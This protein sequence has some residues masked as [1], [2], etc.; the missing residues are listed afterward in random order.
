M[1]RE[2]VQAVDGATSFDDVVTSHPNYEINGISIH[3]GAVHGYLISTIRNFDIVREAL[4]DRLSELPIVYWTDE[5]HCDDLAALSHASG[6]ICSNSSPNSWCAVQSKSESLP[7]VIGLPEQIGGHGRPVGMRKVELRLRDGDARE[8][9]LEVHR[10]TFPTADG[11]EVDLHEGDLVT[12]D[13]GAGRLLVGAADVVSS[14]PRRFYR[15]LAEAVTGSIRQLGPVDG[16]TRLR[17]SEAYAHRRGELVEL[18]RDDDVRAFVS[19]MAGVRNHAFP[20]PLGTVHTVD[21]VVETR[22]FYSDIAL[23]DADELVVVPPTGP[24]GIGLMRTER[25]FR[26]DLELDALRVALLGGDAVEAASFERS[27]AVLEEFLTREYRELLLANSGCMA[28][29]RTL[30]VPTNKLFHDGFDWDRIARSYDVDVKR[31]DRILASYLREGETFHGCRGMRMAVQRPDLTRLEIR[32]LLRAA[33][34]VMESG[35][36]ADVFILLSMVTLAEEVDD[37]IRNYDAVYDELLAEGLSLPR[38]RLSSMVETSAIYHEIE[39]FS[40]RAGRHIELSG[41]LFGGNDFTSATL[42]MSRADSVRNIIPAYAQGGLMRE[43]PF[44]T[45]H[46]VVA[47]TIGKGIRRIRDTE[48][49]TPIVIGFGGEQAADT[50][51]IRRLQSFAHPKS[52]DFVATSPDRIPRILLANSNAGGAA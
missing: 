10:L 2:S 9:E 48:G 11:G 14:K 28:V 19:S 52:L 37:Y 16:W 29:I 47:R 1:S 35:G 5:G 46:D 50:V 20:R 39:Q 32:A 33:A 8:V 3:P 30:C 23:S 13:G 18:F 43:N 41:F 12:V 31:A 7:T 34:S 45:L 38:M 36:E 40:G 6:F 15:T 25:L 42:N 49:R 24:G 27:L 44:I 22:L 21:A 26:E 17:E 4:G 51:S